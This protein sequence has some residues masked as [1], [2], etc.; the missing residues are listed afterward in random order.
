MKRIRK[1]I[2]GLAGIWSLARKAV[3]L[4]GADKSGKLLFAAAVQFV[5]PSNG[6]WEPISFIDEEA[7]VHK[8]ELSIAFTFHIYYEEYA[9][10]FVR[11]IR[12]V[13]L[14]SNS[15]I[16]ITTPSREIKE[17]I[18]E[19]LGDDYPMLEVALVPNR[20]RNFGP[21]LVEYRQILTKFDL[22]VHLH[23]KKSPHVN[24]KTASKWAMDSW[25]LLFEDNELLSRCLLLMEN[26]RNFG[27][28]YSSTR[29][30]MPSKAF[31]WGV[32]KNASAKWFARNPTIP[33]AV[34]RFAFPAGGMFMA[35]TL[36]ILPILETTYNYD[37]F[38]V[39]TGQLDGT[40]QHA[41]ERI[42]GIVPTHLNFR[43]C[44]FVP[45]KGKFTEDTTFIYE[46]I[47]AKA[48]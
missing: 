35:R 13:P 21:L 27:L 25:K 14:A 23:S 28:I 33:T 47:D 7:L 3:R 24:S 43:H 16:F 31:G 2:L 44:V 38:P 19:A 36:A 9:A 30:F 42:V 40:Y 17:S 12:N 37:D 32:S 34:E 46:G 39:E 6:A 1:L 29:N 10:R 22:I 8:S 5:K 26:N 11:E 18:E 45:D 4:F 20:G 15:A 48:I 41:I